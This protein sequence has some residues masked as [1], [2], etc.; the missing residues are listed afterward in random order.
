VNKKSR[1][2]TFCHSEFPRRHG[3]DSEKGKEKEKEKEKRAPKL[4]KKKRR[5]KLKIMSR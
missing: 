3:A 1:S 5:G 2:E 4:W